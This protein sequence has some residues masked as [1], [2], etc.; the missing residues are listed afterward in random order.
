MI[1][2]VFSF[3]SSF[4]DIY[5][6]PP[7]FLMAPNEGRCQDILCSAIRKKFPKCKSIENIDI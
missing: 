5:S 3:S 4:P 7:V 2:S 1:D 6:P